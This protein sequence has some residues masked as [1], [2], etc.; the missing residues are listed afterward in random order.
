MSGSPPP[1]PPPFPWARAIGLGIGVLKLSPKD[2]W[3]MTP[4]ELA[5]ALRELGFGGDAPPGR[6]TLDQLMKR[7]P[8]G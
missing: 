8:D 2:F 6:N 5:Y 4:R 1:F 7:F 3:T